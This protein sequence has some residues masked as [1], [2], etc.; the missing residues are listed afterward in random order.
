MPHRALIALTLAAAAPCLAQTIDVL[1]PVVGKHEYLGIGFVGDRAV[2]YL[3]FWDLPVEGVL[4]TAEFHVTF[5][6]SAGLKIGGRVIVRDAVSNPFAGLVVQ[7]PDGGDGDG[8]IEN[9]EVWSVNL[10]A[11]GGAFPTGTAMIAIALDPDGVNATTPADPDGTIADGADLIDE[12][13]QIITTRTTP[14]AAYFDGIGAD[15][16]MYII[17]N[18]PTV[19]MTATHLAPIP[20]FGHA[21]LLN[22]TSTSLN[23]VVPGEG[24]G[25][26]FA[27]ADNSYFNSNAG[28]AG[29]S[30]ILNGSFVHPPGATNALQFSFDD[31][32][33]M[34]KLGNPF[35]FHPF[36][37]S[38]RDS[39]GNLATSPVLIAQQLPPL[40]VIAAD[41]VR[42]I[43]AGDRTA[44]DALRLTFS[45]P[46]N[47]NQLGSIAFY[48][49]AGGFGES[50]RRGGIAGSFSIA[51]LDVSGV[52]YEHGN[53]TQVFLDV[54][55]PVNP[56]DAIGPDGLTQGSSGNP[57][58]GRCYITIDASIGAP[59]HAS[60]GVPPH[61]RAENPVTLPIGSV[62][63]AGAP[64]E[65]V[66][67]AGDITR[68]NRTD[69]ADFVMIAHHFGQ[70]VSGSRSHGDLT[71]DGRVDIADFVILASQ[72][73]CIAD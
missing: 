3:T 18:T 53:P 44:P 52:A 72:F 17:F 48:A 73:G 51:G 64:I 37:S 66:G 25:S 7:E 31:A 11:V 28:M 46:L 70:E 15:S 55:Q 71:G 8:R 62:I 35:K 60:Y 43:P 19:G 36:S 67:C 56:T 10:G 20:L 40:T 29:S 22:S 54:D 16:Q 59:V 58:L 50:I 4:D 65:I 49:N 23:S 1:A 2:V 27:F 9:G 14:V 12:R 26:D 41:W 68:D 21:G 13:L 63:D 33:S 47:P 69:A 24:S 6:N 34:L 32:G 38:V 45:R 39:A 42:Q 5:A 30:D 57:N 61:Y